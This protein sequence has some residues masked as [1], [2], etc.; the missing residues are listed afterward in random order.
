MNESILNSI[1]IMNERNDAICGVIHWKIT[2]G[3]ISV[4]VASNQAT[5][6]DEFYKMFN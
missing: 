2:Y 5:S 1:I 6:C 3:H 4:R